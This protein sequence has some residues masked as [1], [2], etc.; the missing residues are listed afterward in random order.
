MQQALR[1]DMV[2]VLMHDD[3]ETSLLLL[4]RLGVIPTAVQRSSV[5]GIAKANAAPVTS[6]PLNVSYADISAI[7]KCISFEEEL[8]YEARASF[9]RLCA[10]V[11]LKPSFDM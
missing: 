11:G 6:K 5:E 9:R 8:Y 10:A 1:D 2:I 4:D 7:R 3:M